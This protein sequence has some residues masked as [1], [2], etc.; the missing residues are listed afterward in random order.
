MLDFNTKKTQ[1]NYESPLV[2]LTQWQ[3]D[4]LAAVESTEADGGDYDWA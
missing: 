1:Q 2:E 3:N 4:V